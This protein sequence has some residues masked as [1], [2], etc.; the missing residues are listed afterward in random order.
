MEAEVGAV[1]EGAGMAGFAAEY[2]GGRLF[3]SAGYYRW[4]GGWR[5]WEAVGIRGGS[6]RFPCLIRTTADITVQDMDRVTVTDTE[7][8]GGAD[9]PG[10]LKKTLNDSPDT[11]SARPQMFAVEGSADSKISRSTEMCEVLADAAGFSD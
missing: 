6:F 11:S 8:G 10:K 2:Y 5:W 1:V 4:N 7:R 9:H 3:Y